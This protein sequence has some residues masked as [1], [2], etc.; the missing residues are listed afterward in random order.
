MA[1]GD[2]GGE[3]S[4]GVDD[5]E[6]E[7]HGTEDEDKADFESVAASGAVDGLRAL[8]LGH[9]NGLPRR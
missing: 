6:D 5:A 2:S 7:H 8:Q 9:H 4:A 3:Q 1:A